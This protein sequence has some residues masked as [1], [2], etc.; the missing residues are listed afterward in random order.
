MAVT[1]LKLGEAKLAG[2][3]RTGVL[4]AFQKSFELFATLAAD[5]SS[6]QAL[7]DLGVGLYYVSIMSGTPEIRA[8]LTKRLSIFG[9]DIQRALSA[10]LISRGDAELQKGNQATALAA[11]QESF[12]I[13]LKLAA[14]D[15]G[16]AWASADLNF[17]LGK[18]ADPA[19]KRA[20]LN[21][22]LTI[23]KML[24]LTSEQMQRAE[25]VLQIFLSKLP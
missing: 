23:V 9:A 21:E 11:Y 8:E 17:S 24:N 3:D 20:V 4:A 22:G 10:N 7:N 13:F 14:Q 25:L 16:S 2:G 1:L 6:G 18:I 15:P 5:P 19:Q 12:Y